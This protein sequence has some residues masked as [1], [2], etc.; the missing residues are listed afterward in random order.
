MK[1]TARVRRCTLLL[2]TLAVFMTDARLSLVPGRV[3]REDLQ[4]AAVPVQGRSFAGAGAGV[5]A[6]LAG[7]VLWHHLPPA[8]ADM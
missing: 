6:A 7:E 2:R 8:T 3:L 1:V 5:P 4:R